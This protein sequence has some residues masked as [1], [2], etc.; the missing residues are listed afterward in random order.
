[1][2]TPDY[3]M[4]D[5]LLWL[6]VAYP[7]EFALWSTDEVSEEKR[8]EIVEQFDEEMKQERRLLAKE[9]PVFPYPDYDR[10]D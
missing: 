9:A 10:E 6:K 3:D 5:F 1:M 8:Q 4:S 2:E 7:N